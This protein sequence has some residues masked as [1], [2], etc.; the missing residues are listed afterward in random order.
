MT[1]D[2]LLEAKF[3][4]RKPH[5]SRVRLRL[6]FSGVFFSETPDRG[7]SSLQQKKE[8]YRNIQAVPETPRLVVALAF[9][10]QTLFSEAI[11]FIESKP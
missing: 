1:L 11:D 4:R 2:V 3:Y 5:E 9:P 6:A 8:L 10:P 7:P